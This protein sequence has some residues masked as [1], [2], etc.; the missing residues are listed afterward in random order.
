MGTDSWDHGRCRVSSSISRGDA[1]KT[2]R[3]RKKKVKEEGERRR[4]EGNDK[5][6]VEKVGM[7]FQ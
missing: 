3:R 6:G 2:K 7:N 4:K 1:D 5:T